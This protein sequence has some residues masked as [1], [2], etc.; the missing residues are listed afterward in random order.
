MTLQSF[1]PQINRGLGRL[2]VSGAVAAALV[3]LLRDEFTT[4]EAAPITTPRTCEPGPGALTLVQTRP[5][6]ISGQKLVFGGA[7]GSWTTQGG[8]SEQAILRAAGVVIFAD[9]R[10][11]TASNFSFGFS[12]S[13]AVNSPSTI[14]SASVDMAA[15]F[16]PRIP[17]YNASVLFGQPA[18]NQD[19][20]FG[21]ILRSSGFFVVGKGG[22]IGSTYKLIWPMDENNT[23][24]VYPFFSNFASAGGMDALLVSELSAPWNDSFGIVT[25]RRETVLDGDEIT[26]EANGF[27]R[28]TWQAV[29]GQVLEMDI[30][31]TDA[32]NRWIV[33]CDQAGSTIK[34]IERNAGTE[35]ERSSA[36]QTWTNGTNYSITALMDAAEIRTFV[37]LIDGGLFFRNVYSTAT[38]NQTA[39]IAKVDKAGANL[40]SWPRTL[41]GAALAELERWTS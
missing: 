3:Y 1:P 19:Y 24:T 12:S 22:G 10:F 9:L 29:T 21:I 4:D 31:R 27:V 39:T 35:T 20:R 18:I 6:S 38:F 7:P 5:L 41:S 33:R 8:Y 2:G 17:V 13:A 40:V 26:H 11:T 14:G 25:Q 23:A 36:A 37:S 30:R 16:G 15:N 34:I 28:F 32:D